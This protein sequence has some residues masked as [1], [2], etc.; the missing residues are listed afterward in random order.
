MPDPT[1]ETATITAY[2][3]IAGAVG[4]ALINGLI[5]GIS[6]LRAKRAEYV[7]E[8]HKL[9]LA[10]RISAYEQLEMFISYLKIS[11]RGTD[12][13]L[14]HLLFASDNFGTAHQIM[15]AISSKG[16]WL[17]DEAFSKI[18]ELN[19]KILQTV[20]E[21]A[22]IEFGKQNYQMAA[23][24]RED[25]ERIVASDMM[26]LHNVDRFLKRKKKRP[27]QEFITISLPEANTSDLP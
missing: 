10:K 25:L 23:K 20:P 24:L 27:S 11:V 5:A 4:G 7:N 22:S 1:I 16:L 9:V 19:H 14:Y 18:T 12:D 15:S 17:S 6:G 8:Y 21:T 2:A 13:R 3:A 26:E